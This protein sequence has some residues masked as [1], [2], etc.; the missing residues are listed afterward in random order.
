MGNTGFQLSKHYFDCVSPA[1]DAVIAYAAT[2]D[3]LGITV[4]YASILFAPLHSTP[5]S[6]TSLEPFQPPRLDPVSLSWQ[7][8]SLGFRGQWSVDSLPIQRDL[9]TTPAG[10]VTWNCR[11]HRATATV[12]FA[13]RTFTGLGYVEHLGLTLAPW[14]LPIRNLRWGRFISPTDSLIWLQWRG[15]HP[16]DLLF[17]NGKLVPAATTIDDVHITAPPFALEMSP[18]RILRDGSLMT[19]ALASVPSLAALFPRSILRTRETKWLSSATLQSPAGSST[20]FA[21]HE[22]VAFPERSP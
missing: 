3:W 8:A 2:L 17:H 15:P 19:T 10:T 16:L 7:H 12:L 9:L 18:P 13:D 20:G 1:G 22:L 11:A 5:K 14:Q 21:I 6:T 4:C